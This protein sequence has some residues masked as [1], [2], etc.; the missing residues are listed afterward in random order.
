MARQRKKNTK[1]KES[2]VD[3]EDKAED[4]N[5]RLV[6]PETGIPQALDSVQLFHWMKGM[7]SAPTVIHGQERKKSEEPVAIQAQAA[8]IVKTPADP[9]PNETEM[10]KEAR[11]LMLSNQKPN[12]EGAE[13]NLAEV[14]KGNRSQRQGMQLEYYPPIVKDG[15]KMVRLNQIEVKEQIQKWQAS[16]IGEQVL[17]YE[18]KPDFCDACFQI[19]KHEVNCEKAPSEKQK[20]REEKQNRQAGMKQQKKMQWKVKA[21]V[22]QGGTAKVQEKAISQDKE[23]TN[24]GKEQQESHN[25]ETQEETFQPQQRSKGKQQM[26]ASN[27]KVLNGHEIEKLLMTNR[28]SH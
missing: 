2:T 22:E 17:E 8:P 20:Y 3:E 25:S 13:I 21:T 9:A 28:Y 27:K 26:K 23:M 6:T 5:T 7:G 12:S 1:A 16:L 4:E 19:G 11:K 10:A 18:W 14:V 24:Q 15:V